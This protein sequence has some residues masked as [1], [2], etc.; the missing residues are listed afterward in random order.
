MLRTA[1]H[2]SGNVMLT[3]TVLAGTGPLGNVTLPTAG[4]GV[5]SSNATVALPPT[6]FA[7]VEAAAVSGTVATRTG[8][9]TVPAAVKPMPAAM[10]PTL[11]SH[12]AALATPLAVAAN[13]ASNTR[14][15]S[16]FLLSPAVNPYGTTVNAGG[17]YSLALTGGG[18]GAVNLTISQAR[19]LGTLLV[20][21][22]SGATVTIT[23]PVS[24][25]TTAPHLPALIVSGTGLTVNITGSTTWLSEATVGKNLKPRR[26]PL[27]RPD[28]HDHDRRLPAVD[29]GRD[30][31]GRVRQRRQ[32]DEQLGRRRHG[33]V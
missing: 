18:S 4:L 5:I 9:N 27:R 21:A 10:W 22:P 32:G 31:R 11:V 30:L 24:W 26:Q 13:G 33:R 19:I 12:Y 29:P 17:I 8:T 15:M 20:T 6:L 23:G 14:A 7:N 25:Q 2:A 16:S 1:V 28:Q 3:S